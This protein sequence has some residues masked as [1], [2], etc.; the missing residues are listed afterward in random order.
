MDMKELFNILLQLVVWFMV[1]L[2]LVLTAASAL[3]VELKRRE[4]DKLPV[5]QR[6]QHIWDAVIDAVETAEWLYSNLQDVGPEKLKAAV[7]MASRRLKD[8]GIRVDTK[9]LI[10]LIE[11]CVGEKKQGKVRY[12]DTTRQREVGVTAK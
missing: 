5:N 10:Y 1:I 11:K 3:R 7:D 9:L 4:I 8:L 6:W 2:L 12:G